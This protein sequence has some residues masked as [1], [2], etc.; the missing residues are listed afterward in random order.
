MGERTDLAGLVAVAFHEPS[1]LQQAELR[2]LKAAGRLTPMIDQAKARALALVAQ[3]ERLA[4][5]GEG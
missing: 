1:K 4:V 5:V 2:Y 3:H